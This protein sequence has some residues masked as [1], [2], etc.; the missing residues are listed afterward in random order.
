MTKI[1]LIK[2]NKDKINLLKLRKISEVNN[3]NKKLPYF[4][5]FPAV[6]SEWSNSIYA[7]NKNSLKSIPVDNFLISNLVK[8]YFNLFDPKY[9]RNV[10]NKSQRMR[11][12]LKR[13][14][15][16]RTFVSRA[17]LKHS[18]SKVIVSSNIYDGAYKIFL[19]KRFQQSLKKTSKRYTSKKNTLNVLQKAKIN[20]YL[21]L[22]KKL[23]NIKSM[24]LLIFREAVIKNRFLIKQAMQDNK[25]SKNFLI[26]SCF[27]LPQYKSL[28]IY[29]DF[30]WKRYLFF[31]RKFF[32]KDLLNLHYKNLLFLHY[33][34]FSQTAILNQLIKKLFNGKKIEFNFTNLKYYYLNGDILTESL[35][36]RLKPRKY[37][38]YRL[39]KKLFNSL[40][41]PHN[42]KSMDNS[43]KYNT[44][45]T[46][47]LNKLNSYNI[48]SLFFKLDE[49]SN[50]NKFK[51]KVI[52]DN[53][54]KDV[55]NKTLHDIYAKDTNN[56]INYGIKNRRVNGLRVKVSGRISKRLTAQRSVTKIGSIGSLKTIDSSY[57]GLP[58]V[59]LKGYAR[60]NV[61]YTKI[62][63]K[64][65]N[66]SF[67]LKVHIS[68]R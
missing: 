43:N 59:L 36:L 37:N 8:S 47:L 61:Q 51:N 31:L 45:K 22:K 68:S 24:S 49:K 3:K 56:F 25:L 5:Q 30:I 55:L 46:L 2:R 66:G 15:M 40:Q 11:I 38:P 34:K 67:G 44:Y 7:Y 48:N 23:N 32:I 33:S 26:D 1:F 62:N 39:L 54:E 57:N 21:H 50:K 14:S 20:K 9:E 16:N 64:T 19:R 27:M 10:E 41:F 12:R 60:S 52:K 17:T 4:K 65:R 53:F 63:S 58:S 18:N 35:S 28:N 29:K 13:L 6:N 42:D